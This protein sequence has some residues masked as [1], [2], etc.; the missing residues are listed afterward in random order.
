MQVYTSPKGV[1]FDLDGVLIDSKPAWYRVMQR[2]AKHL[3]YP[4]LTYQDFHRTFGQ[5]TQADQKQFFPHH[6]SEE[7]SQFY[8]E[9]LLQELGAIK[10]IQGAIEVLA[11]LH[12]F[13]IHRGVVTNTSR[14]AAE[15]IL[16]AKGLSDYIDTLAAAGDAREKPAP[17]LLFLAVARLGLKPEQV[18]YVGDSPT[19]VAAAQAADI[20]M[21]GFGIGAQ[22]TIT[23]LS[24]LINLLGLG[25]NSL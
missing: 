11:H 10:L 21:V 1:L 19:D 15:R 5:G 12:A 8:S 13:N 17:D 6:S 25:N 20:P 24:E 18:C 9:V 4:P 23:K 22:I 2:T 3:G 7:I 14:D 16:Q